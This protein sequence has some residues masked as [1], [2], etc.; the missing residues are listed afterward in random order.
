MASNNSRLVIIP[1]EKDKAPKIW[2]IY[3]LRMHDLGVDSPMPFEATLTNAVP[4]GE[5]ET[6]GSFGPWHAEAPG[7]TPLEGRFDSTTPT[8]DSSRESPA[9]VGSRDPVAALDRIE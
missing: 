1:K 9:P 4:P 7:L 8:S 5:I 6:K 3:R 2:V